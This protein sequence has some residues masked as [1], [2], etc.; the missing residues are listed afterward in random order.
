MYEAT[1]K[2]RPSSTPIDL[3]GGRKLRHDKLDSKG[4]VTLRING[5][6]H[7]IPCGRAYAGWC[8]RVLVDDLDIQ[9]IGVDGSPL[10]HL[11]LDPTRNYQP[12]GRL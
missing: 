10:R 5:R 8:V 3:S 9:V 4:T 1:E 6:M 2:A 12:L 11:T 7:H